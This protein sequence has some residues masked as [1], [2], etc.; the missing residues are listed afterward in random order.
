[1]RALMIVNPRA[2]TTTRRTRDVI[3][4]AL[5]SELDLRVAHTE[6]RDHAAAL[7]RIAAD[8]GM[9]MV[10]TLGGDGTVNEAVNGILRDGP[11]PALPALAPLPGGSANVF[12]RALGLPADPVE[13]TGLLL[14]AVRGGGI[15]T[16]GLGRADDRYFTFCAGAGLDAEVV[17]RMEGLR[18]NG[19]R[20]TPTLY[21]QTAIRQFFRTDR[22][23]PA[24]TIVGEDGTETGP[25]LLAIISNTAPWT[26][27]GPRP[28]NPTP[29]ASFD[30][31]LDVFAM[32]RMATAPTLN[33]IRQ[34]LSTNGRPPAGRSVVALHDAAGFTV[35]GARPYAFQLDGEYLGER[36]EVA[37][38]SV[39]AALRVP[40]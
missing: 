19:R 7:A 28:V 6:H 32:R 18:A 30:L 39:P 20:A 36:D 4:R 10:V 22:R 35:R 17:H 29:L 8:D 9:D 34:M 3:V 13:A 11:D 21:I 23:H 12:V 25:L 15:R 27:A 37:F 2:T 26:Y 5:G 40:V 33:V 38:R 16:V 31:G 24:L 14:E 1:M